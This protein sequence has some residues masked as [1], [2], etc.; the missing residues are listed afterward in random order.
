MALPI[1]TL[2]RI[3]DDVYCFPS[4]EEWVDPCVSKQQ[5]CSILM[6]A[7]FQ[8]MPDPLYVYNGNLHF[9]KKA[10]E[11]V[12][13]QR[14]PELGAVHTVVIET[15]ETI[16]LNGGS[17]PRIL[18]PIIGAT[19]TSPKYMKASLFDAA[20][21]SYTPMSEESSALVYSPKKHS[22]IV[23]GI[24]QP[25]ADFEH[26]LK[27]SMEHPFQN[28]TF[29]PMVMM[30]SMW[31]N[32]YGPFDEEHEAIAKQVL[33]AM[34]AVHRPDMVWGEKEVKLHM[35]KLYERACKMPLASH[36]MAGAR[37]P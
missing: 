11:L 8:N 4:G 27:S 13:Y 17:Y 3:I 2:R 20:G 29:E 33:A 12:V 9:E 35:P 23:M 32:P 30:L 5:A 28:I 7:G 15:K 16:W 19:Y 26:W 6:D 24:R 10:P 36:Y 21:L 25:V 34:E 1:Y 18:H 14:F 22:S 31:Y 37:K